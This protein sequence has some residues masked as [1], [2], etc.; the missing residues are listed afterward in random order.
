MFKI[1]VFYYFLFINY[2]LFMTTFILIELLAILLSVFSPHF[3]IALVIL[4]LFV[5]LLCC[6]MRLIYFIWFY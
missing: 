2:L 5:S 1:N 6:Y 3:L 4:L